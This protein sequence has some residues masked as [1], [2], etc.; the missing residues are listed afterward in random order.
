MTPNQAFKCRLLAKNELQHRNVREPAR[1]TW[2]CRQF[3][4]AM[5]ERTEKEQIRRECASNQKITFE[6]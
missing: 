6:D 2:N 5:R 4:K 1:V 3:A